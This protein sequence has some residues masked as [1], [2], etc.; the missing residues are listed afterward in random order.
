MPHYKHH[1]GNGGKHLP[2]AALQAMRAKALNGCHKPTIVLAPT[3]EE[4]KYKWSGRIPKPKPGQP[5][6]T[7]L[8]WCEE[9][10]KR[11]ERTR[12]GKLTVV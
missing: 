4:S 2:P 7:G 11:T 3:T 12:A 9:A 1:G 6:W 8:P 10:K 5:W